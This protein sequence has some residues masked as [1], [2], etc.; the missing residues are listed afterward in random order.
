MR[1]VVFLVGFMYLS[2]SQNAQVDTAAISEELNA[3]RS[4]GDHSKFW[5]D[6]YRIDQLYRGEN[7]VDSLDFLNLIK[8]S[9][10]F[11]KFGYPSPGIAGKKSNIIQFVWIHTS[12]PKVKDLT[13]P[14][15]LEGYFSNEIDETRLRHYFINP[16]Y[17]RKFG[18]ENVGNETIK[19]L[20]TELNLEKRAKINIQEVIQTYTE[21]MSLLNDKHEEIGVWK[22]ETQYD[23]IPFQGNVLINKIEPNPIRIFR[24]KNGDYYLHYLYEDR[25]HYPQ[26]LYLDQKGRFKL[27]D[28]STSYFELLDSQELKR[29]SADKTIIYPPYKKKNK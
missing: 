15:L 12:I 11:N 23:S 26:R 3:F 17:T 4:Y 27:Y 1:K 8:A 25:S 19:F 2:F 29:S 16:L 21:G 18:A 13:F 24:D 5:K 10:Y 28:A 6:I 14:M 22:G 7:T 9:M 20:L